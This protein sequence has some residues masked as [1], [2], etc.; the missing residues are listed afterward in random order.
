M[1]DWFFQECIESSLESLLLS[2]ITSNEI[3]IEDRDC[4]DR[5]PLMVA[6]E[7]GK[8]ELARTLLSL[9]ANPSRSSTD[10]ETCLSRAVDSGSI[11]LLALL[12]S[13]GANIEQIGSNFLT[14]LSLAAVT[15]Q[16]RHN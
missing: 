15:R 3:G 16:Q 9:G 11:E 12:L 8:L 10:G 4:L 7:C 5:T 13:A 2:A 6:I 1:P 14:P